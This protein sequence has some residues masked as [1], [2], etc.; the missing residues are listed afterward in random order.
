MNGLPSNDNANNY[1]YYV[2]KDENKKVRGHLIGAPHWVDPK[3]VE[4]N[5]K[6]YRARVGS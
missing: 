3:D 5:P 4:L 2:I 1:L 6:I